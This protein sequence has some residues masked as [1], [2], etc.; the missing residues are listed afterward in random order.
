MANV[1]NILLEKD[2]LLE[3]GTNEVEVLVFGVGGYT[4]GINVAKVRE[5]LPSQTITALPKSHASVT[6]CFRLR[7]RVIP[8]VSLHRHLEEESG[9]KDDEVTII[10]T[11]FN[12]FQIGFVVDVV[13]RIHRISWDRV[14][15]VPSVLT[16]SNSPVTAVANIEDRLVTMLDFEMIADQV[17][18]QERMTDAV[19]NSHGVP[20]DTARILLADD[21][22]TVRKAAAKILRNSGYTDL[23]LFEDGEKAWNWIRQKL[24]ETGTADEVASLVISD[25]EMP[26]IDGFRL[27]KNIKSDPQLCDIPVMLYSSILTPENLKKGEFVKA[28]AQITKPELTRIVKKADE[29]ILA[30]R[31]TQTLELETVGVSA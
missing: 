2:I 1:G 26:R 14:M 16:N 15:A 11:E 9:R 7:D 6:G 12:Q 3:S 23:K 30:R 5:V 10:L 4:F 8:C 22:A 31:T 28:D 19:P 27:T 29:L 13:E 17:S 21:S 18:E 24:H 20:R 25:V